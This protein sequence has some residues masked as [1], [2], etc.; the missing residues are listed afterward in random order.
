[1]NPFKCRLNYIIYMQ[2]QTD[3]IQLRD[4][5]KQQRGSYNTKLN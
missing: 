1:M 3:R 4:D 5:Y 2:K